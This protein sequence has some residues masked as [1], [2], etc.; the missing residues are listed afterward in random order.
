MMNILKKLYSKSKL[1]LMGPDWM[2]HVLRRKTAD[3]L[4]LF[5]INTFILMCHFAEKLFE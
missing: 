3:K 2:N 5:Y 1:T 4:T